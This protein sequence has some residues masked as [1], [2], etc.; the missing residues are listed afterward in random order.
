MNKN[1]IGSDFEDFLNLSES[2]LARRMNTSR[3]N[4]ALFPRRCPGLRVDPVTSG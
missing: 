3:A 2:E 4:E 1:Y